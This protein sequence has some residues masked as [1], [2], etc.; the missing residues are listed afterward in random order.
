MKND[1]ESFRK[2]LTEN[3]PQRI[4]H[5]L[6]IGCVS[7]TAVEIIV[8]VLNVCTDLMSSNIWAFN[9]EAF[10]VCLTIAVLMF[11]TDVLT[12][13]LSQLLGILI[14]LT[15]VTV[16]VIGLGGFVFNW[17]PM[18]WNFL[19]LVLGIIFAVYIIVYGAMIFSTRVTSYQVNKKII[20]RK[21][22]KKK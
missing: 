1:K 3:L 19:L 21:E 16:V 9:L 15:D 22:E 7:F 11:F 4:K 5:Y 10:V 13:N 17:F 12:Y 20:E 14:Q 8:S 6:T 18:K 2:L